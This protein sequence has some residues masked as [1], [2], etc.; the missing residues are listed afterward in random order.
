[1]DIVLNERADALAKESIQKGEDVQYLIP[2]TDLKSYWKT[3]LR[4]PAK[5]WYRESGK[6]KRRKPKQQKTLVPEIQVSK[7]IYCLDKKN[8][9]WPLLSER[10]LYSI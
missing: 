4:V 2:V 3:K 7:K 5:E 1:M 8:K 10:V 6:Q 9:T